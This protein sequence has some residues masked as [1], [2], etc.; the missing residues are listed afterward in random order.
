MKC[1]TDRPKGGGGGNR[2]TKQKWESARKVKE[3]E[4][5]IARAESIVEGWGWMWT[6]SLGQRRGV[7]P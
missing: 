5:K 7:P 2:G 1:Q 3:L 4:S 6:L